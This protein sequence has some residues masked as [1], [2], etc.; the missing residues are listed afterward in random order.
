M[1]H[2]ASSAARYEECPFFWR[3]S[4]RVIA[5]VE[6]LW[7]VAELTAISGLHVLIRRQQIHLG[8]GDDQAVGEQLRQIV[9]DPFAGPRML[10]AKALE[11]A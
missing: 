5:D 11:V 10:F 6:L 8:I 3:W 7:V 4:Q 2:K 1:G 9:H